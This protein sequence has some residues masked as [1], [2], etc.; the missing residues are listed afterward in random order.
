MKTYLQSKKNLIMENLFL[1]YKLV[2]AGSGKSS[3]GVH[4]AAVRINNS[5]LVFGGMSACEFATKAYLVN[6][7]GHH[8]EG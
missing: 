5:S 1:N 7:K 6:S 2:L 4:S 3:T 8:L